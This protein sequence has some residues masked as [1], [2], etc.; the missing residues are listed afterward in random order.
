MLSSS[1]IHYFE[2]LWESW[3]TDEVIG[4]GSISRVYKISKRE[5][6]KEYTSALKLIS[7]PSKD[8]KIELKRLGENNGVEELKKYIHNLVKKTI[9]EVRLLYELKGHS[10]IISYEDHII[11]KLSEENWII[12]LRME[13]VKPLR[14]YII[15]NQ[16][17]R[18]KTIKLGIDICTALET[19]HFR[20]K[21]HGSINESNIYVSMND[22]FKLGGFSLIDSE[23]G[24][25]YRTLKT[26]DYDYIPPE[27]YKDN[28]YND[29]S[30]IYSLGVVMY[31]IL[32]NGVYLLDEF[33]E[34]EKF[35]KKMSKAK[36]K[37]PVHSFEGLSE[38]IL[39]ACSQNPYDRYHTAEEFK[40]DLLKLKLFNNESN[41]FL[42]KIIGNKELE[43]EVIVNEDND[44]EKQKKSYFW[45]GVEYKR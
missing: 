33:E 34:S 40:N 1:I 12:L 37:P 4:K 45:R 25:D 42:N 16:F 10:N 24:I 38:I 36:I 26:S 3:K 8:H 11:K 21:V 28:L 6:G 14:E 35:F 19:C 22:S 2:P 41:S 27:L 39:K 44:D 18:E 32:N 23:I 5:F 31:K 29:K 7:L 13:L 17:T 43:N 20:N 9:Y 30:D 15:E